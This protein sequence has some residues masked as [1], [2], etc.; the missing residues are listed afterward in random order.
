MTFQAKDRIKIGGINFNLVW[1]PGIPFDKLI[2]SN[3]ILIKEPFVIE[4]STS[5]TRGYV[6]QWSLIGNKLYLENIERTSYAVNRKRLFASWCSQDIFVVNPGR[7]DDRN[8]IFNW[9]DIKITIENG[10]L[11]DY[12]YDRLDDEVGFFPY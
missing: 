2:A 5:C 11:T 12:K 9:A 1:S 7:K 4:M 10:N 6:A 3:Q 8:I